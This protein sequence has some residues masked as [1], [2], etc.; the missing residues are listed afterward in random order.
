MK[1]MFDFLSSS[2]G[3]L[4]LSPLFLVIATAIRFDSTGPVFFRQERVGRNGIRFRI[5]KFRSMLVEDEDRG[6][7][8]TVGG[9]PRV[10][11]VGRFLRRTK[12]DELPQLINVWKGEMSIVGPRPEVPAYVAHYDDCQLK[13][14]SVR[15]GITDLAS[16]CYMNEEGVLVESGDPL[17]YYLEE[18][19]PRKLELN[20]QYIENMSLAG[21]M[22]IIFRT[23]VCICVRQH[24]V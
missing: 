8:I 23:I 3:L 19:M 2:L 24:R 14:L 10:T 20:L 11:R 21:D 18:I 17:R 7:E 12:L 22:K 13:V 9:D 6:P 5:F 15:P 4:F 16:I 1:R